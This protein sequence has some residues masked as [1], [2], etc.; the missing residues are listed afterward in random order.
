MVVVKSS[1]SA[2][3]ILPNF[4][5]GYSSGQSLDNPQSYPDTWTPP[6]STISPAQPKVIHSL[7]ESND[8][9]PSPI[10]MTP[11]NPEPLPADSS[12]SALPPLISH[13]F[14]APQPPA[15]NPFPRAVKTNP[16][17]PSPNSN[18]YSNPGFS[19]VP[20][21]P[22]PTAP[23]PQVAPGGSVPLDPPRSSQGFPTPTTKLPQPLTQPAPNSGCQERGSRF[24]PVERPA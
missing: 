16:E 17:L 5:P 20:S 10:L 1:N 7:P 8:S 11:A 21:R 4:Q 15:A 22:L 19:P 23:L 6:S 24:R 14:A 2:P 12:S 9:S 18:P 3:S 13:P